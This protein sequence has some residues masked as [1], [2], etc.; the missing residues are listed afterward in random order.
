[1]DLDKLRDRI[2]EID[3]Q[4]VELF[5]SRMETVSEV[6]EYKIENNIPVLNSLRETEVIEKNLKHLK[7]KELSP[8]LKDFYINLM[9][10]SKSY[11]KTKMGKTE[12]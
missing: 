7:N 12:N 1:M 6:S 10:I 3:K 5:E 4:I 9:D 11:Q 2:D 8:Y